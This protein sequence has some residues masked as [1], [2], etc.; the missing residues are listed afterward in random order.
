M[1]RNIVHCLS[2][3]F[4]LNIVLGCSKSP[5]ELPYLGNKETAEKMIDGK[6]VVDTIYHKIPDFEFINQD[7]VKITQEFVAGKIYIADFFFTTCPTIC[8]KMKTQM[9]RIYEKYK[10]NPNVILL[11]HSIDPRHD[12]PAVLKEFKSNLGIKGN[13]WQM[14]TGDKAKIFE[15]GQKSYMV[16]AADDPTQPGGV[17]HSG[18]FILVDKNRH[19]RGI[20]D[21]T[22]PAKV[23]NLMEDMEILLNESSSNHK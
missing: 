4:L 18:A 16:S 2:L 12:T 14:V 21:G 13:S 15:I 17:V 19:I 20:Y 10:D 8:P 6:M 11:S 3:I 9:L 7:S 22:V 1:K 5:K 23:D